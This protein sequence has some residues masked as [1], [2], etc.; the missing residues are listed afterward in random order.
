MRARPAIVDESYCGYGTALAFTLD[1]WNGYEIEQ[2]GMRRDGA[3]YQASPSLATE[4][5]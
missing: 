1:H 2:K 3:V 4:E 5:K